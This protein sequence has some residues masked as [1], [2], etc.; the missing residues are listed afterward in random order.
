LNTAPT[1][2][3][4][5][6]DLPL[7]VSLERLL[8]SAGFHCQGFSSPEAFLTN[9][10]SSLPGCLVLDVRLPRQNG[11]ELYENMR[12]ACNARSTVFISGHGSIGDSVRAMKAGAIDFLVKPFEDEVLLAAVRRALEEDERARIYLAQLSVIHQRVASLTARERQVMSHVV[13]GRLNKQIAADLG[14]SEKTI[15][16]HRARAMEKMGVQ[17]L[18]ELVRVS[19]EACLTA[20]DEELADFTRHGRRPWRE[21]RSAA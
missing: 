1:I 21:V 8:R 20:E 16:V 15:K 5:D 9:H 18:A 13:R 2:F 7:L 6:D 11:L 10:D 14:T 4:V 3:L 17:S 12:A 19:M